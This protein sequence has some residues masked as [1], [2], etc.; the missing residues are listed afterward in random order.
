MA[1]PAARGR[2]RRAG[3]A[4]ARA[5]PRAPTPAGRGGGGRPPRPGGALGERAV[6]ALAKLVGLVLVLGAATADDHDAGGRHAGHAGEAEELPARAHGSRRLRPVNAA[7][8]ALE[9]AVA[10]AA[11]GDL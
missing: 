11:T 6:Q 4:G 5:T 3:G 2:P 8:I 10:T 1:A 9:E 7:S